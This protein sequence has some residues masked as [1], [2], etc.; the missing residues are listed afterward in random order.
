MLSRDALARFDWLIAIGDVE[1]TE[2]ELSELAA[3]KEPLVR[4]RGR[5]HALR[6]AERERALRFLDTR[7]RDASVVDLARALSGVETDEAGLELGRVTL[8]DALAELVDGDERRYSAAP[9]ALVGMRHDLFPFQERGHGWLRLLGDLGAGGISPNGRPAPGRPCRRSRCSSPNGR[10]ASRRAPTAPAVAPMQLSPGSGRASSTGSHQVS[11]VHVHHG[12]DR[13]SGLAFVARAEATDV[14]ITS[15]D[16]V[17]RDLETF[18]RIAW[19]RLI[20]DEAQDAKNRATQRHRALRR[21]PR[22]RALALT[23]TPIE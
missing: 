7:G 5:W 17:A 2:A 18:E 4:L 14:V 11:G 1:L 20:L 22:R 6:A 23:G 8:D 9:D 15:Y 19:D 12:R 10:T 16:V 21:L 13:L 3:A